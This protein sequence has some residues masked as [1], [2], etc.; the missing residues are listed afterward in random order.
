[1]KHSVKDLLEKNTEVLFLQYV[2]NKILE[3]GWHAQR[4]AVVKMIRGLAKVR[5][6]EEHE[7]NRLLELSYTTDTE[8]IVLVKTILEQKDISHLLDSEVYKLTPYYK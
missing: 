8:S 4:D 6:L 1:M 5:V 2:N 3:P 7:A